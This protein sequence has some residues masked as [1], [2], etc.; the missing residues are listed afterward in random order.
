MSG[1]GCLFYLGLLFS[2]LYSYAIYLASFYACM[3]HDLQWTEI[4]G[5]VLH[6]VFSDRCHQLHKINTTLVYS[7]AHLERDGKNK[8]CHL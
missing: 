7:G 6:S 3:L 2:R 1:I 5:Q 8:L 4:V